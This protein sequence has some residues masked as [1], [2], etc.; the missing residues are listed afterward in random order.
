MSRLFI[1]PREIDFISDLTKEV[2]KDVIGQKVYYYSIREDLTDIHDVYEEAPDKVF[3]PPI[4]IEAMVDWQ[5]EEI[6]TNRFGMEEFS[7]IE[8]YMHNR[9]LIDKEINVREG[10]F[11]SYGSIFFEI[12]SIVVDKNVFGQVEHKTG[13]KVTGKQ[14]RIGQIAEDPIGPTDEI[15]ADDDAVQTLFEQQRGF[16]TNSQG[17][18]ADVRQLQKDGKLEKPIPEKPAKVAEDGISST[19]YGDV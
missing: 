6:R 16:K 14:A 15:Y 9:D 13:I 10:D 19:F 11:F 5:P 1:T 8:V 4:E 7:T 17:D 12:T 2:V 3:D 18:T